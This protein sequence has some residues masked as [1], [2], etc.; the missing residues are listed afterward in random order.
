MIAFTFPFI[1]FLIAGPL[2]SLV[3]TAAY[4]KGFVILVIAFIIGIHFFVLKLP[5][6]KGKLFPYFTDLYGTY[7]L[8]NFKAEEETQK[9]NDAIRV[10]FTAIFTAWISPCTVWANNFKCKSYFLVVSSTICMLSHLL[11]LMSVYMSSFFVEFLPAENPPLAHCFEGIE[12]QL[13]K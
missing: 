1:A 2:Y 12:V 11:C 6:L 10:L 4:F 9:S 5:C 7:P 3:I 13:L 8:N